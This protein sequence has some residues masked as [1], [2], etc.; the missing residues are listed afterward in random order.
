MG[1]IAQCTAQ[2]SIVSLTRSSISMR[3][4][5]AP[6]ARSLH[7][8][9]LLVLVLLVLFACSQHLGLQPWPVFVARVD[10]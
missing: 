8:P 6:S 9:G 4:I 1:L 10:D 3:L 2:R 7:W 5:L